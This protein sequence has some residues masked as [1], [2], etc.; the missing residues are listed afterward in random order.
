MKN[1]FSSFKGTICSS[2][3]ESHNQRKPKDWKRLNFEERSH[4]TEN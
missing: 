3:E 2:Y 1:T 4:N